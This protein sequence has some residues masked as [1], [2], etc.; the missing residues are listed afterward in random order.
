MSTPA[1]PQALPRPAE[2]N[3]SSGPEAASQARTLARGW[4]ASWASDADGVITD[5]CL[6]V[7]ELAANAV[8]HGAP[9]V[10]LTLSAERRCSGISVTAA[11]HD[12]SPR[13]PQVFDAAPDDERHR[14]LLLVAAV[15]RARG[16]RDAA[17][18]GK[19]VW[20]EITVPGTASQVPAPRRAR[21]LPERTM[22]AVARH[23]AASH[24]VAI[25]RRPDT[26][27]PRPATAV[28]IASGGDHR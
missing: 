11:V 3:L 13:M 12:A 10:T 15:S 2:W 23:A 17:D 22:A 14:G 26:A 8:E 6:A 4:L 21:S 18:G 1:G 28:P 9:P 24:G 16:V 20:F 25:S 19:D 5:V 7:S 27:W